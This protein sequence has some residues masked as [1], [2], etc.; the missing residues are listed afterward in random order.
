MFFSKNEDDW[1]KYLTSRA[2][3]Y[4]K[5]DRWRSSLFWQ[6][7]QVGVNEQ[8]RRELIAETLSHSE[9]EKWS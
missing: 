5:E 4:N 1:E 2:F 9:T 7:R 3:Y 8:L 6:R